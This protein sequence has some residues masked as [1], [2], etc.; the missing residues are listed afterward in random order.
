M[1]EVYVFNCETEE[2]TPFPSMNRGRSFNPASGAFVVDFH[3]VFVIGG[4]LTGDGGECLDFL[5]HTRNFKAG[6]KTVW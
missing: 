3:I 1:K 4:S 6:D 5:D 2:M